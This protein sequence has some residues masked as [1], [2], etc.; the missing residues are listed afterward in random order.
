MIL[1]HK[2]TLIE[3]IDNMRVAY[4]LQLHQLPD[5]KMRIP[6]IVRRIIQDEGMKERMDYL[7]VLLFAM[8]SLLRDIS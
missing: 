7:Y 1:Y 8:C 6:L 5:N 3:S 4:T 2:A